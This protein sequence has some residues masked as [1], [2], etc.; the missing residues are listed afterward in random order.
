V[1]KTIITVRL[2]DIV[3]QEIDSKCNTESCCRSDFI[4]NA[5]SKTLQTENESIS[6]AKITKISNDNGETWINLE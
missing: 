5:I 6:E 4:K 2:D 1:S 3:L